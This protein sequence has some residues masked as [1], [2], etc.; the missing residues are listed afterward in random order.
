LLSAQ[1]L[2]HLNYKYG[3]LKYDAFS[4][5]ASRLK[6]RVVRDLL[7]LP[8]GFLGRLILGF[9]PKRWFPGRGKILFFFISRNN[10]SVLE[11]V[12]AL[13]PN[14][15]FLTTRR[16]LADGY[17]VP[18]WLVYLASFFF[19]PRM[20]YYCF[21]SSKEHQTSFRAFFRTYLLT[22]GLYVVFRQYIRMISP[23]GVVV[24]NDHRREPR[25]LVK[26]CKECGIPTFF[27]PHGTINAEGAAPLEFDFAL[28]EGHDSLEKYRKAGVGNCQIYLLGRP[29]FDQT[30]EDRNRSRHLRRLGI[31]LNP[32]DSVEGLEP[33]CRALQQSFPELQIIIR[34]HPVMTGRQFFALTA[35]LGAAYSDSRA[36]NS[37]EFM[38]RVDAVAAGDSSILLDAAVANVYPIYFNPGVGKRDMCGFVASGLADYVS[39]IE[40]MQDLVRKLAQTKPDV[41]M[42]TKM[43]CATVGTRYDGRSSELARMLIQESVLGNRVYLEGWRRVPDVEFEA[44][45]PI[46]DPEDCVN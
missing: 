14:S 15:V 19:V 37:M 35:K 8:F 45:E 39:G 6:S 23:K 28:L 1:E 42:R 27:I 9:Q 33:T 31:C 22:F 7:G 44:Y 11:P 38:K 26:V 21:T 16:R 41:R 17:F 2:L 46:D 36:E 43:Y 10:Y 40:E 5:P 32:L 29:Y 3:S 20:L 12:Q 25:T 30:C 24:A 34:P 18:M 13:V 4:I